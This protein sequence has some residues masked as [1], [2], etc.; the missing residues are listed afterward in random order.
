MTETTGQVS[1]LP[2]IAS[3][4]SAALTLPAPFDQADL[5]AWTSYGRRQIA[6][7]LT[8]PG[9]LHRNAYVY[10]WI[11]VHEQVPW[12]GE[13][14]YLTAQ[15]RTDEA[16]SRE[17]FTAAARDAMHATLVPVIARY[18]FDRLWLAVHRTRTS[19]ADA[20]ALE[21]R[22][23]AAWWDRAGELER[24]HADGVLDFRPRDG[25]DRIR[26]CSAG[27]L[28]DPEYEVMA[29]E[30]LLHGERVGWMTRSGRLVP[31]DEAP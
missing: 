15:R 23:V 18:G 25:D 22:R 2:L 17:S 19:G 27:R 20:R 13:P 11:E 8:T 1:L 9:T 26:C 7:T 4:S 29:A 6:L 21:A 5:G 16:H 31:L 3:T 30:A 14:L 24:C 10:A 12:R 28:G